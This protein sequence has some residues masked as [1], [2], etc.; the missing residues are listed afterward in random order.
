MYL[1]TI[2]RIYLISDY[3]GSICHHGQRGRKGDQEA[4]LELL[5][6][7]D[8]KKSQSLAGALRFVLDF[9]R[10]LKLLITS[11]SIKRCIRQLE[12]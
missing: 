6:P 12:K 4:G 3:E 2:E 9:V 10:T 11:Y 5:R 1:G 7:E 8:L